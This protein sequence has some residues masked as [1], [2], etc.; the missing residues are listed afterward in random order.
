[1]DMSVYVAR[2]KQAQDEIYRIHGVNDI[3]TSSKVYEILIAS[4]LDHDL[5]PGQAGTSDATDK[6]THLK[7]FEY[8]H[9]KELSS[10]HSWTF[11]DFSINI[12]S[13][14]EEKIDSIFFCHVD[15]RLFPPYLDWFYEMSGQETASYLREKTPAIK[16][17]R[18]MIN[19]SERQILQYMQGKR[20]LKKI[21]I[22]RTTTQLFKGRYCSELENV[23][24]S[25]HELENILSMKNLLTSSKIW[26]L[27]VADK[28][29]HK[30]N[31]EQGGR[32]GAH[33]ASD[34]TGKW[35]EYK[36]DKSIGWSFQDISDAVLSKY[37]NLEAFILAVVDK[38]N[39]EVK[40][41]FRAETKP[42]IR[43]LREKR[44]AKS[45]QYKAQNKEVRR[46]QVTVGTR[47]L[48]LVNAT[49]LL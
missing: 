21:E 43:I 18:K 23:F 37:L 41:I 4:S 13:K 32:A 9:F 40:K 10:N 34:K 15:D 19:L 26:E 35:Y 8:K 5:I 11:N 29:G 1:M 30:V 12:F 28:L 38:P 48:R 39:F 49:Q 45:R 14:L 44:D 47:E 25:I 24:N 22:S 31:S 2:L 7:Q 20:N 42:L 27:V 46:E 33:D 36:V 16:N 17:A 3:F 6:E